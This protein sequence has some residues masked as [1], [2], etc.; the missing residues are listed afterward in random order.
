MIEQRT[1]QDFVEDLVSDC[2]SWK[3]ICMIILCTRWKE[4]KQE[5]KEVYR[6][7]KSRQKRI[8]NQNRKDRK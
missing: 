2:K 7:L 8:S 5:I 1:V 4:R 6:E 3:E